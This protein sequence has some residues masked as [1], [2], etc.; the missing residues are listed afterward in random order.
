[1]NDTGYLSLV[2][3]RVFPAISKRQMS[4]NLNQHPECHES[5]YHSDVGRVEDRS[6]KVQ[7]LGSNTSQEKLKKQK[8]QKSFPSAHGT[9]NAH[10]LCQLVISCHT[11]T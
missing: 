6:Q 9:L 10:W 8:K 7:V 11:H 2:I 1:L 5:S 4:A 3:D